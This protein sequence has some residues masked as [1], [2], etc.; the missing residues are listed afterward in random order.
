MEQESARFV[1]IAAYLHDEL[2]R[3]HLFIDGKGVLPDF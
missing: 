1:I 2:I 3:I